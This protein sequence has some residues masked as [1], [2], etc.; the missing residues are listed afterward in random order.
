M[1]LAPIIHQY[2]VVTAAKLL[3]AKEKH[4]M[5]SGTMNKWFDAG[6]LQFFPAFKVVHLV[7]NNRG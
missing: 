3:I 6:N 7:V 4:A 2:A 1:D 5:H